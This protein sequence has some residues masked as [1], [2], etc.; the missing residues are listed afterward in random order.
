[1]MSIRV[2]IE[3][4]GHGE[5]EATPCFARLMCAGQIPHELDSNFAFPFFSIGPGV[6]GHSFT[7]VIRE[8][9]RWGY[10]TP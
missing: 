9:I 6:D 5:P 7:T 8:E 2:L 1:M 10:R 4:L 3:R